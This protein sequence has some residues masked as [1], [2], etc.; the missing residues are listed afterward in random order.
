MT[1]PT[2]LFDII[3]DMETLEKHLE[4]AVMCQTETVTVHE[5][6]RDALVTVLDL[7]DRLELRINKIDLED[8]T[9]AKIRQGTQCTARPCAFAHSVPCRNRPSPSS[10]PCSERPLQTPLRDGLRG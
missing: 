10:H 2:D 1:E 6:L 8:N 4:M 3:A 5:P 7:A 9:S